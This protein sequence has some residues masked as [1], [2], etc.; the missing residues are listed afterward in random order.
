MSNIANAQ[1][2]LDGTDTETTDLYAVYDVSAAELKKQ[3]M[4][5]LAVAIGTVTGDVTVSGTDGQVGVFN[6]SGA[7]IGVDNGRASGTIGLVQISDGTGGFDSDAALSFDPDADNG[8]VLSVGVDGFHA[9]IKVSANSSPLA[10]AKILIGNDV[11]ESIPT[12]RMLLNSDPEP[13]FR[14]GGVTNYIDFFPAAVVSRGVDTIGFGISSFFNFVSI[15]ERGFMPDSAGDNA[16]DLGVAAGDAPYD[17]N[18]RWRTGYFGTS[19]VTPVTAY[20]NMTTTERDA[21]TPDKGWTI[22]NSTDDKLQCCTNAT[23]PVWT[24]LF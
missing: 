17:S 13:Q 3:T 8:P 12:V 19:V 1:H 7:L 21:L 5:E 22:Y 14:V 2:F 10:D 4:A 16:I 11:V 23:G 24:N 15:T 9:N 20:T 6:G 18:L